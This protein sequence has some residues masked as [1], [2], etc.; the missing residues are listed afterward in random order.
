MHRVYVSDTNIWIDF[1][2][3]D[4]LD[5]LFR[6]PFTWCST[7]FVL[8]EMLKLDGQALIDRG[9]RVEAMDE[10]AMQQL[11]LLKREH[12][13]SSLADVSCLLLARESGQPLLTG[14][15][16]LRRSA[17]ALGLE[18]HGAL[19]IL[20][21]LV[22]HALLSPPSAAI[23]LERMLAHHARLPPTECAVR[24]HR[25]RTEAAPGSVGDASIVSRRQDLS[26]ALD[27]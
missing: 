19:W 4:V 9:L 17:Q 3:A 23:A 16:R 22:A 2:N 21:Q 7:D 13:N 15:G 8:S 12:H 18:V 24:L 14:D 10:R 11:F 26:D 1:G 27:A 20:D 6:L 5:Q 25:W